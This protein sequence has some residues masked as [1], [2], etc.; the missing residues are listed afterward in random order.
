MLEKV[1]SKLEDILHLAGCLSLVAVA[2]LINADILLRLF[3]NRPVQIQFEL[4]ELFLMPALATLS[5]SRVFRDGGHLA[6]EFTPKVL[7]GL[8]GHVISLLRLL[9][10]AAFFAAVTA[11]SGKFAFEAIAHG[12]VEYGVIDWPLGWAY[13]VIPLGCGVLVLRLL[14][15][16]L[17]K[18]DLA[19]T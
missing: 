14:H 13:A 2:G 5:L 17:M 10:P 15:D 7:P 8:L 16:A 3:A 1:L 6:L 19:G 11:M 18:R 4:T 9:L 12:H